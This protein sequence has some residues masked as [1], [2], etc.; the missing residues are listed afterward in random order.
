[1]TSELTLLSANLVA[2]FFLPLTQE[3]GKQKQ[4]WSVLTG[5]QNLGRVNFFDFLL[6][7]APK[8]SFFRASNVSDEQ[9]LLLPTTFLSKHIEEGQTNSTAQK[10]SLTTKSVS[11]FGFGARKVHWARSSLGTSRVVDG[12]G[13]HTWRATGWK[14]KCHTVL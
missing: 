14:I 2:P 6:Q 4:K 3:L 9:L 8:A 11:V 5:L 13:R 12:R 7:S 10:T 1:M